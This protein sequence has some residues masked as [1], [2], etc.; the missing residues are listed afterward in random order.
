MNNQNIQLLIELQAIDHKIHLLEEE[1]KEKPLA[2]KE[3]EQEVNNLKEKLKNVQDEQKKIKV[4]I[5]KK[6]LSLKEKEEKITKLNVQL[7]TTKTNKEYSILLNEITALKSDIS[8]IEDEMLGIYSK[9]E[10]FQQQV[11]AGNKGIE[12][13]NQKFNAFKEDANQAIIEIDKALE[14]L[15]KKRSEFLGKVPAELVACYEKITIHTPNR[16]ALAQVI[17]E[18]CQGCFMNITPQEVND[19]M[20]GK[21]IIRCRSCNRILYL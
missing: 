18:V 20:K 14:E 4:E 1:K 2:L 6:D 11:K 9:V 5:D 3:K 21:E 19:L 13:A 16:V 7:N 15:Y 8:V 12:E 17:D 10:E